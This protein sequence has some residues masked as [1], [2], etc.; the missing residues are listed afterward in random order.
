MR[1][2][3]SVPD[4][5]ITDDVVAPVLEA[6]TRL[7]EKMIETGQSPTS[8]ELV[9]AGAEWRPEPP[10]DEHFD[11]GGTI[12]SRGWGDCDDWAALHAATLRSTGED[13]DATAH[14]VPSGPHTYH[15]I[16]QRSDGSIEDPSVAAGMTPLGGRAM[17]IGSDGTIDV[18]ACD[19]H[20]GRI[21]SGSLVPATGPLSIHCGPSFAVRGKLLLDG[22]YFE[23][24]CD[25]PI[26]GSRLV[27]VRTHLRRHPR[28]RIGGLVPAAVS[29]IGYGS[30]PGEAL[31]EAFIGA[32]ALSE[33]SGI[34]SNIDQYKLMAL[35][36][37]SA[38]ASPG[39]V[40]Q[41]LV[42]KMT[43]D[44]HQ[45]AYLTNTHP[46]AHVE[47]LKQDFAAMEGIAVE[48]LFS[49][50]GH[51]AS[52]I[53]HS[54]SSAAKTVV[55]I[56]N[57]V[58]WSDLIH[59]VQA[60]VSAVPGLGTA[61]SDVVSAAE[62]AY[63]SVAA[64]AKGDPLEAAVDAAYNF[65]LGTVPGAAA[66]HPI[67]DPVKTTLM[68]L[69]HKKEPLDDA[70]L[71]GILAAIPEQPS[72]GKISPRSVAASLAHLIVGHLGMRK[73]GKPPI[74]HVLPLPDQPV[75]LPPR[76][77]PPPVTHPV[78]RAILA[79]KPPGYPHAAVHEA[80]AEMPGSPGAPAGGTTWTCYRLPDGHFECRW[81]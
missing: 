50:I 33:V 34:A 21:Y 24:R 22:P 79:T 76:I 38:G 40:R 81:V 20:D 25:M 32:L 18:C 52:G 58:P 62:T 37:A 53:V 7:N 63:E 3:I 80:V 75:V 68:D 60:A 54:V 12:S 42:D 47:Q 78:A 23:G 39:E 19:P 74:P 26:A 36:A 8:H 41:M 67:L 69:V 4:E 1:I 35:Q 10:G 64:L 45:K 72:F 51:L 14:I 17:V 59:D 2:R 9:A 65:A 71:N 6:V 73:T 46:S 13:P 66:L 5:L 11:H 44:V 30:S 16:V 48:G 57:K 28:R 31:N 43:E 15:A 56:A 55:S 77:V 49:D 27:R 70:L 61:V 29:C